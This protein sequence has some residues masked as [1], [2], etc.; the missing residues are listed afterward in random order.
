MHKKSNASKDIMQNEELSL[1]HWLK[2]YYA[3]KS[4]WINEKR[5]D[6]EG[7]SRAGIINH[8]GKMVRLKQ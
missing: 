7:F 3:I 6:K 8:K 5:N 1:C 2:K 4:H